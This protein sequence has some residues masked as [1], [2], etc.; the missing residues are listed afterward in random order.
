MKIFN[1]EIEF[2]KDTP[3][4]DVE[5]VRRTI[6]MLSNVAFVGIIENQQTEEKLHIHEFEPMREKGWKTCK[7]G[8]TVK[9]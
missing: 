4:V 7:C 8:Y 2:K 5:L 1:I 9:A 6:Q 3:L